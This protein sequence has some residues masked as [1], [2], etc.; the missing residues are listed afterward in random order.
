VNRF[1]SVE[2]FRPAGPAIDTDRDERPVEVMRFASLP[3]ER[4]QLL[5]QVAALLESIEFGAVVVVV[6]DG[7]AIQVEASEKIRLR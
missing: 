2:P 3:G 7:K 1:G 5:M 6:Q 4:R